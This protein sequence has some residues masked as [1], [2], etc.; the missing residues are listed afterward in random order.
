MKV[1]H[2]H[3]RPGDPCPACLQG[4]LYVLKRPGQLVWITA[5][6]PFVATHYELEKLRCNRC[7]RLFTAP[8]PPE[9]GTDKHDPSVGLRVGYLRFGGGPPHCRMEKIQADFGVRL[10]ASTQWG[11]M[12]ESSLALQ[13]AQAA[14]ITLAAQGTLIYNDDTSMRVQSLAKE[15]GLAAEGQERTGVFTTGLLSRVEGGHTVALFVTGHQH[16]GENLDQLLAR[17]AAG[18]P[19]PIQMCDARSRNPSKEFKRIVANCLAHGRRHFADIAHSFPTECQHVLESLG[20]VCKF[21]AQA[22]EANLSPEARLLFHQQHSQRVMEEL[23]Q[24][25]GQ[26]V[27]QKQVEPNSGLGQA[28]AYMLKHGEPL[29]LFLRQAGAPLDNNL[30]ERALKMAILHRKN[31]LSYK[32]LKGARLGDLFMS[33]IHTCRLNGANPLDYLTQLQRHA[34]QVQAHPTA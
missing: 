12:E 34:K 32:T 33:L 20:E 17:R 23:H 8:V 31:S 15:A 30:C 28:I 13:P 18:L 27:D 14:L 24:G 4:K 19:P 10:P 5:Q 25:L 26:Q 1:A 7:G 3:L 22:R 16:A 9:A 11:C 6:A 21:D 2:P 29:T